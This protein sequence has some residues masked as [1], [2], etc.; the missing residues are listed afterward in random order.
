MIR[1]ARDIRPADPDTRD[2]W[3]AGMASALEDFQAV[4][5]DRLVE[6]SVCDETC[7]AAIRYLELDSQR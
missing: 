5:W 2:T 1:V 6:S 4:T 7:A 3:S